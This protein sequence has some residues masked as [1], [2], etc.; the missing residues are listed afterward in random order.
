MMGK[1][2]V[3][4]R[5]RLHPNLFTVYF[6][7][8]FVVFFHFLRKYSVCLYEIISTMAHLTPSTYI[9]MRIMPK[10]EIVAVSWTN[11]MTK[12]FISFFCFISLIWRATM[13]CVIISITINRIYR[14][15]FG[16]LRTINL[17]S[18]YLWIAKI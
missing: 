10:M 9:F 4:R 6:H 11:I 8:S 15:V 18:I 12:Y 1:C 17:L 5:N 7:F 16:I 3:L 2:K 14:N 13:V